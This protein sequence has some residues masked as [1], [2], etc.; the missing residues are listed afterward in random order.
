MT[1]LGLAYIPTNVTVPLP[2]FPLARAR[3]KAYNMRR[4]CD[5]ENGSP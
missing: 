5:E 2:D 4:F 1:A 3:G